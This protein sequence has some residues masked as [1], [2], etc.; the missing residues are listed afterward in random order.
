MVNDKDQDEVLALLPT[1]AN[2]YFTKASIPRAT[3][4]EVLAQKASRFG[5]VGE[6]YPTVRQA[7]SAAFEKAASNDLVFV[8]GSTFVVAEIL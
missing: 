1:S 3:E 4:P 2:Y 8:G 5:L 7:F 6:C